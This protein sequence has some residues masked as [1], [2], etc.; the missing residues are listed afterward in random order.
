MQAQELHTLM[1]Q[2]AV[3]AVNFAAEQYQLTLDGSLESLHQVD[4]LL[5]HLY[6]D[7][8]T[9]AHSSEML[10]TLCNIVGAYVGEVFIRHVG[11]QWQNNTQDQT[12]PYLA[13]GFGDKE[14][15]FASICYHKIVN[16]N[17]ISLQDYLRQARENATQ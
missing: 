3:D 15:P 17:S 9:K 1:Q 2:S 4:T 5:S 7:Q 11:G 6:Q 10:F 14:F 13:V 8:Q 12:A 16:D